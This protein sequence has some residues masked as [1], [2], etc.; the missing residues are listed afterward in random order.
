MRPLVR[1]KSPHRPGYYVEKTGQMLLSMRRVAAPS[2][3]NA[4]TPPQVSAPRLWTDSRSCLLPLHI[5]PLSS[6][7]HETTAGFTTHSYRRGM[8]APLKIPRYGLT[9]SA[10]EGFTRRPTEFTLDLHGV[11]SITPI[12]P[13]A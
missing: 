7:W 13:G 9:E 3:D 6:R 4:A 11:E 8:F 2:A 1:P 10:L 5:Y 12:V